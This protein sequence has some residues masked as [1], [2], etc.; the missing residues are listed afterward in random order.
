MATDMYT[1]QI[2]QRG[3][4]TIPTEIR[5]QYGLDEDDVLTLIDLGGTFVLTPRMSMVPKL[6]REIEKKRQ[7]AG[8]TVEEL[9]EDIQRDRTSSGKRPTRG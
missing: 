9:I 6:A 1:L 8:V 2:R 4:V 5:R 7:R 3:V